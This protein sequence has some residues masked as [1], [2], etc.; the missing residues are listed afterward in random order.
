LD[1]LLGYAGEVTHQKNDLKIEGPLVKALKGLEPTLGMKGVKLHK[2][3][4]DTRVLSLD[5]EAVIRALNNIFQN[6]VEAMERMPK[7]EVTVSLCEDSEGVHLEIQDTGEGI[8]PVNVQKVF[9]PFFT[10]RAF[11]NH[12]GL[13]LSVAFGILKEHQAEVSLES[14]RGQ[15]TTVK[16]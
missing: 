2:N 8:D 6:A 4:Q 11:Q 14:A 16:I 7:K 3:I 10:T 9:D 12:M 13:G 15:G 5:V 1:K